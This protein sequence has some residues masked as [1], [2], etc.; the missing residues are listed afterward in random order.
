MQVLGK[1]GQR[2]E[3]QLKGAGRTPYRSDPP[4]FRSSLAHSTLHPSS[5]LHSRPARSRLCPS[6]SCPQCHTRHPATAPITCAGALHHN[7]TMQLDPDP[8]PWPYPKIA[9]A[10]R[11]AGLCSAP[12]S[13]SMWRARPWRR[14]G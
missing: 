7:P 3:L 11:T 8:N 4:F 2:W 10:A 5:T 1:D 13:G 12:P 6:A 14:W 9:A